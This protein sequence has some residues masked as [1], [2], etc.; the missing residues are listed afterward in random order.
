M[1]GRCEDLAWSADGRWLAYSYQVTARQR[2]IKLCELATLQCSLVTHPEFRDYS[3]SFDPQGQFL[4]FLSLRTYDPVYDSVQFE[5]SFPRAA[6]PYLV[7]LQAGGPPPFEREPKGLKTEDKATT[8]TTDQAAA[9]KNAPACTSTW[10][11]SHSAS[12]RSRST[13]SRF[14]KLAAAAQGKVVWTVL[15]IEGQQGR[16]GHKESTGRLEVFDFDTQRVDTL[17]ERCD[18]FYARG[19]PQHAGGARRQAAAR[20]RGGPS[21]G[22]GAPMAPTATRPRAR[23]AGSTSRASA[24]RCEPRLEWRQML[25][26][27]WRLQRDHFWVA[28]MSGIDWPAM[29]RRYEPLLAGVATR[30]ELSDLIW[31]L[32]GE[33]GTSHAYEYDGD[34]RKPPP[35]ALGQAG[36]RAAVGGRPTRAIASRTSCAAMPGT[37]RPI[38]R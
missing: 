8:R 19:R 25:R 15:P 28:D 27:V 13:E 29:L 34:H 10:R 9:T 23:A 36:R 26:E 7:A 1:P 14:G 30:A 38:H 22:A 12:P 2:A 33:L 11:A 4:Y 3:P 6:R 37:R 32:Q 35:V 24:C 5:M 16:G 18:D 17:M 31:E 21:R 20:H